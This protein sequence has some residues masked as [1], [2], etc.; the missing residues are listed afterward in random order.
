MAIIKCPECGNDISDKAATCPHC[1]VDVQEELIRIDYKQNIELN[2]ESNNFN[3]TTTSDTD[4]ENDEKNSRLINIENLLSAKIVLICF[5]LIVCFIIVSTVIEKHNQRYIDYTYQ[6][7]EASSDTGLRE[8]KSTEKTDNI[9]ASEERLDD[10]LNNSESEF[11]PVSYQEDNNLSRSR[12]QLYNVGE[13]AIVG[14]LEFTLVNAYEAKKEDFDSYKKIPEGA[15]YLVIEYKYKNI[16]KEPISPPD[17]FTF[18]IPIYV[19]FEDYNGVTYGIDYDASNYLGSAS[20]EKMV[21][22]LNPGITT[23]SSKVYEIAID[24]TLQ[25]GNAIKV[26]FEGKD[27]DKIA[28]FT[29]DNV[30]N[31]NKQPSTSDYFDTSEW[32]FYDSNTRYLTDDEIYSLTYEEARMAINEIAARHGRIF[33]DSTISNYFMSKSWYSPTMTSEEYDNNTA[34]ILNNYESVNTK[35][36]L[37]KKNGEYLPSIDSLVTSNDFASLAGTYYYSYTMSAGIGKTTNSTINPITITQNQD[38]TYTLISDFYGTVILQKQSDGTY[39]GDK[40]FE[41]YRLD[42]DGLEIEGGDSA[43]YFTRNMTAQESLSNNYSEDQI[44]GKYLGNDPDQC[45]DIYYNSN[46]SLYAATYLTS[47]GYEHSILAQPIIKIDDSRYQMSDSKQR[48]TLHENG[49]VD[50]DGVYYTKYEYNE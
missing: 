41:S 1:G 21:S 8:D 13:S 11:D 5:S 34:F 27:G 7:S 36:L 37:S 2:S 49:L 25:K 10:S 29:V 14:P 18:Q 48:L 4:E 22:S 12:G 26:R 43:D 28:Y 44:L 38:N 31:R 50:I 46:G 3:N 17:P 16:S 30:W 33:N 47:G 19:S 6:Y 39:S 20:D 42:Y 32:I 15:T 9:S 35:R 24:T 23:K 40:D 45:L